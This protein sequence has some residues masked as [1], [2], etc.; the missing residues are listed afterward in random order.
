MARAK[1]KIN[2]SAKIRE[3]L[4]AGINSPSE[5]AA[6]LKEEGIIVSPQMVSMVKSKS[7]K[8]S[9]KKRGRPSKVANNTSHGLADVGTIL[10]LQSLIQ[11]H[12]AK[13]VKQ[14]ID[15]IESA[16]ARS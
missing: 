2:K 1:G 11:K 5:I 4:T 10:G 14:I 16:Q 8:R 15:Q 12:G 6:A 7:A 9:P 13:S 3:K